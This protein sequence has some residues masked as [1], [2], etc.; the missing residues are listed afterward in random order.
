MKIDEK[1]DKLILWMS[2]YPKAEINVEGRP[3]NILKE[4]CENDEEYEKILK[5]YLEMRSYYEYI[6]NGVKGYRLRYATTS[7]DSSLIGEKTYGI[8]PV[9]TIS[10]TFEVEVHSG[11]ASDPHVLKFGK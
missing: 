3:E 10:S 4:Y 9:I 6:S 1:I 8:R 5:E 7:A 2:K 11:T